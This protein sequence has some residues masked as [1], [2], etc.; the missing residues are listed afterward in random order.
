MLQIHAQR[1]PKEIVLVTLHGRLVLGD[2]TRNFRLLMDRLIDSGCQ[3]IAIDCH[4]IE[5]IDC[6]GLGELVRRR[7]EAER[8][9]AEI[10]LFNVNQS[11]LNILV[12]TKLVT[13]FPLMEDQTLPLAA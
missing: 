11:L 6:A 4:C 5:K 9:S 12:V 10:A 2:E 8:S 3:F 1:L 13:V 7:A